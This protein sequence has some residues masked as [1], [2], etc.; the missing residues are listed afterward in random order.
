MENSSTPSGGSHAT[1]LCLFDIYTFQEIQ[2]ATRPYA[3]SP[4]PHPEPART[5]DT[6]A[7]KIFG[8]RTIPNLGMLTT[9]PIGSSDTAIV[10]RTW[11]LLQQEPS[12]KEQAYGPK[13]TYSEYLRTRNWLS[14]TLFHWVLMVGLAVIANVSPI[15]NLLKKL[16]FQPG[17]GAKKEDTLN[18]E[19]EYRGV[20]YPDSEKETGKIAFCRT[21]HQGGMYYCELDMSDVCWRR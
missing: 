18:E 6:L 19:I 8:V 20:A 10:E 3:L 11:G 4:I 12:R 9:S 16:V 14:G 7:Q 5:P 15:R 13:F 1:G 17:Q 21:Y 2:A